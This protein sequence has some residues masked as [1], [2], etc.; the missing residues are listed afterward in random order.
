MKPQ[1]GRETELTVQ[2]VWGNKKREEISVK[3]QD[4]KKKQWLREKL[5]TGREFIKEED[6]RKRGKYLGEMKERANSRNT[7]LNP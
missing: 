2:K 5:Q 6:E 4:R 7:H 1:G 3:Q